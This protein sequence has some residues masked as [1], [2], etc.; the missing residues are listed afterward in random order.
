M[1]TSHLDAPVQQ[2]TGQDFQGGE[3][4]G[5]ETRQ[6][7]EAAACT[8]VPDHVT[9]REHI[10]RLEVVVDGV[11]DDHFALKNTEDLQQR[12]EDGDQAADGDNRQ[13]LQPHHH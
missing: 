9:W 8:G 1:T 11:A 2:L 12:E 13:T 4:F 3:A 10:Q 6:A 5:G 7:A